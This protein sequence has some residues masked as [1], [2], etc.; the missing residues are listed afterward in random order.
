MNGVIA[1][2]VEGRIDTETIEQCGNH[3]NSCHN[4]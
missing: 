1:L 3:G 4:E 2:L